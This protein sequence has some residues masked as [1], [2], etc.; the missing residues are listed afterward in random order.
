[1]KPPPRQAV[2][3]TQAGRRMTTYSWKQ[4]HNGLWT[5]NTDWSPGS[6]PPSN[7]GDTAFIGATGGAYTVTYS[8]STVAV[9]MIDLA[10]ATATLDV[11]GGV[12]GA[13]TL[14]TVAGSA[15]EIAA[16]AALTGYGA[17]SIAGTMDVNGG[18][19]DIS[20]NITLDASGALTVA[21]GGTFASASGISIAAGAVATLESGASLVTSALDLAGTIAVTSGAGTIGFSNLNGAGTVLAE[22]GTAIL[23]NSLANTTIGLA[24]GSGT[25]ET[26]G[27]LY[28][29]SGVRVGFLGPAGAFVYDNSSDGHLIFDLAGMRIGGGTS[30]DLALSSGLTIAGGGNGSGTGGTVVLSNGDTLNL[31]GIVGGGP[32]ALRATAAGSGTEFA[33]AAV[34]YAEGTRILTPLGPRPIEAL[35]PGEA[36]LTME[37]GRTRVRPVRWLGRRRLRLGRHPAPET[38]APIRIR[39]DAVADGIPARDLRVSPDHAI[40]CGSVLI[41][42]R[43]L[44]NGIS[45]V[46]EAA[47]GTVTYY[48][49]ELDA[50][51]IVLAEG[52][53]AESYLDTGNRGFFEAAAAPR[54]ASP[55]PDG[56]AANRLRQ[57]LSCAPLVW[58]EAEV[59][60]VWERLAARAG[61]FAPA[62]GTSDPDLRLVWGQRRL[63]PLPGQE[64]GR[65]RFALPAGGLTPR[66]VSRAARP[67]ALRP[68][69]EDR[70][71]LG[72]RVSRIRLTQRGYCREIPLDDP[73]LRQGWWAVEP[74]ADGPRRWT[75][76]A[77]WLPA[78]DP[79]APA[80]LEIGIE[81]DALAYPAMLVRSYASA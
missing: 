54:L 80:L 18:T 3:D 66:L 8:G 37:H 74:E 20:A 23:A 53:P 21:A 22:G 40:L 27:A 24:I 11:A 64:R 44:V 39:R 1:M 43:Q 50:H 4:A 13:G 70:R 12:L 56:A 28:Y 75:D 47:V 41:A 14:V 51:A 38:V 35:V 71:R 76:G 81:P 36:V 7:G 32:W 33:L 77:A 49:L 15:V 16:G 63:R 30:I 29:G 42:A 58:E 59:R 57:R 73:R 5:T 68:W 65:Y 67:T 48:H 78:P 61:A 46:Q 17:S 9:G 60:P 55:Q 69:L 62:A 26:T 6:G 2:R 72:V 10:S 34:C 25:I 52:L 31:S 19:V 79:T 45:I